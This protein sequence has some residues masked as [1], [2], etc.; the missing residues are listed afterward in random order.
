MNKTINI[1]K[2]QLQFDGDIITHGSAAKQAQ[3]AIN[4][5]NLILQREPMGLNAQLIAHRDE[6]E[7]ECEDGD[8][9]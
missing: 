2:L 1:H 6:I 5:I 9:E 4:Q 7:V 8:E 3:Q